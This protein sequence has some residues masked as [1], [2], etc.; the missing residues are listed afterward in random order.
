MPQICRVA[1]KSKTF[2]ILVIIF[3]F[4][5]KRKYRLLVRVFVCVLVCVG[6]CVWVSVCVRACIHLRFSRSLI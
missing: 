2:L 5:A 1:K 3:A 6:V 4:F